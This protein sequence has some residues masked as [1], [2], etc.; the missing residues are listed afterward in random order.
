MMRQRWPGASPMPPIPVKSE[1]MARGKAMAGS[2]YQIANA[3]SA[4]VTTATTM[5]RRHDSE[6][7]VIGAVPRS[8][9]FIIASMGASCR[10][11][12]VPECLGRLWAS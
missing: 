2:P 10:M 8:T 5:G 11:P 1:P 9:F 4:A 12:A 3:V 7:I 6:P